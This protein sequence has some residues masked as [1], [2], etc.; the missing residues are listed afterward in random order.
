MKYQ[1]NFLFLFLILLN[2]CLNDYNQNS[3]FAGVYDSN[4]IYHEYTP[5]LQV[6]LMLDSITNFYSGTDSIDIN[7]DGDYDIIISQHL[8]IPHLTSK[9]TNSLFPYCRLILNN[10]LEVATKELNYPAGQGSF[11]YMNWI[12]SLNLQTRIDNISDWSETSKRRDMWSVPL[13]SP[14][15]VHIDNYG[16]WYKVTNPELY[17]AIK[18]KNGSYYK[19]GW[20]KVDATKRENMRFVSYA[21][22]K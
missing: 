16:F 2:S 20:I 13:I 14:S 18:M 22:E 17:I 19:Y 3:V 6:K 1:I 9:P 5:P 12:D 10:G 21:I 8:Q 15:Y 4:F 7:L 11:I